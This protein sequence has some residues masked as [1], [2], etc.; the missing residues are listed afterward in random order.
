MPWQRLTTPVLALVPNDKSGVNSSRGHKGAAELIRRALS[1]IG[2]L[3]VAWLALYLL[4]I[5]C[6]FRLMTGIPCPGCGMTRAW[7]AAL[8]LD[9]SAAFAYHPLFWVVPIAFALA[10]VREEVASSKLK[11]GIDIAVIVLCVLVVA[12]WI[13]RL[14]N[15]ADAG[16]L[17]GGHAPA[18]VP[19]D[20]IHLETPR[21]ALARLLWVGV[22]ATR[23]ASPRG[24]RQ[25][26]H[27]GCP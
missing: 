18:G 14:I 20:I 10:F 13:V 5:G 24:E 26:A 4:D 15:P 9:F 17:F 27:R 6:V 22:T 7:L 21:F 12:V 2:A 23:R 3:F 25:P 19:T 1:C 8:R 11:R 16:L